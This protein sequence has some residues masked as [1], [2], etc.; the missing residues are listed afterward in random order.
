[1]LIPKRVHSP[2]RDRP[3]LALLPGSCSRSAL[4]C[5]WSG[6]PWTLHGNAV[7]DMWPPLPYL[8]S[9]FKVALLERQS[10]GIRSSILLVRSWV[11]S[12]ARAGVE[13]APWFPSWAA[14]PSTWLSCAAL[15]GV[16]SWSQ[17][18]NGTWD[19]N[20]HCGILVLQ[21]A[22]SLAVPLQLPS[23]GSFFSKVFFFFGSSMLCVY[24]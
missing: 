13:D 3:L 14:G 2:E 22:A 12:L 1:M 11:S 24:G 8:F 19:L 18:R 5:L 6:L 10:D 7:C 17:V 21:G 9:L 20:Q 16:L 15:P 4:P 23:L